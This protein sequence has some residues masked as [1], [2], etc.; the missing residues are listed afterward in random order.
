MFLVA[1]DEK[2]QDGQ[3]NPIINFA[4]AFGWD[5]GRFRKN[6]IREKGYELPG[7]LAGYGPAGAFLS[8]PE[9]LP[10]L[11]YRSID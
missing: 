6:F 8:F 3:F 11:S 7:W 4:I 1:A 10:I 9:F 2:T 5:I